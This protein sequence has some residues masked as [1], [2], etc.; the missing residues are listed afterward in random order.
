MLGLLLSLI[1]PVSRIAGKIADV[2]M[3]QAKA[4]T[5]Q[6]RIAAEERIK[7]LEARRAV[8][9]AES[10]SRLNALMRAGFALP[11]VIYNGKLVLWDKVLALGSTDPLSPE[12]FQ[13]E[14]ACIGFY[15]LYEVAARW[16]R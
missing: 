6:E 3:A 12:L 7:T 8:L 14:M 10:G 5:D 15:F 2:R 4:E 9:V 16:R 11:F 13:V 1:D